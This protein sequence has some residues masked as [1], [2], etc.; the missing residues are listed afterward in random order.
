MKFGRRSLLPALAILLTIVGFWAVAHK[1]STVTDQLDA[2]P[3]SEDVDRNSSSESFAGF[4]VE[5]HAGDHE[6]SGRVVFQRAVLEFETWA[7]VPVKQIYDDNLSSALVGV[8]QSQ[9]IVGRVLAFCAR[10]PA[11]ESELQEAELS[12]SLP[13]A[14]LTSVRIRYGLCKD[15]APAIDDLSEEADYWLFR[16]REAGYPLAIAREAT[17]PFADEPSDQ[18]AEVLAR[19]LRAAYGNQLLEADAL[20][21]VVSYFANS[22]QYGDVD[23]EAWTI[24][25]C[26]KNPSCDVTAHLDSYLAPTYHIHEYDLIVSRANQRKTEMQQGLW[27]VILNSQD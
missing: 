1:E 3:V 11:S 15:L 24:L 19:S 6:P 16:A 22:V 20:R 5:N 13:E 4:D 18:I 8:P 21:Y 17:G 23:R 26:E 14:S 9:Y 10:V 2:R 27:H 25:Y 7:D 12:G